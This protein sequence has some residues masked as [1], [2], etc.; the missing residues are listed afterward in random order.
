MMAQVDVKCPFCERINAVKK[1]GLGNNGHQR[2]RCQLCCRIF[3]LD[4]TYRACQPRMKEQ[5]VDLAM[6]NSGIRDTARALHIS[7]NAVVR[8]LKNSRRDV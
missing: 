8:T 3:Q 1:H 4:Y 7:I 2:Y 6:K 5:I